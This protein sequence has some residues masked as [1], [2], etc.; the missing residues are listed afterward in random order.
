MIAEIASCLALL[1]G[2]VAGI[3]FVLT[4]RPSDKEPPPEDFL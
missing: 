2:L 4:R 1:V 3:A